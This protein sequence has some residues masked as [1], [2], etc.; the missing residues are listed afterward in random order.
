MENT[1]DRNQMF[2]SESRV[3]TPTKYGKVT[4]DNN[5]KSSSR[6][7]YSEKDGDVNNNM[8]YG[9]TVSLGHS[10]WIQQSRD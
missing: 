10:A 1:R 9:P 2:R 3:G 7:T 8:S 5:G 4:G 6:C